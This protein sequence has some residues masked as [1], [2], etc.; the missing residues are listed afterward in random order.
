MQFHC[1]FFFFVLACEFGAIDF[2]SKIWTS[3]SLL[4]E[5]QKRKGALNICVGQ[6][7]EYNSNSTWTPLWLP[8]AEDTWNTPKLFPK[9]L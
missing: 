6:F 2:K 9:K 4:T 1:L 3:E 5:I 7:Y 8:G